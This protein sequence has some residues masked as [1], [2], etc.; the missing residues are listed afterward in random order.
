MRLSEEIRKLHAGEFWT[1]V[2]DKGFWE[3]MGCKDFPQLCNGGSMHNVDIHPFGIIIMH[4]SPLNT[5]GPCMALHNRYALVITVD[6]ATPMGGEVFPL[7]P[8]DG[9]GIAENSSWHLPTHEPCLAT[10]HNHVQGFS[11]LKYLDGICEVQ[12]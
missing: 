4:Q 9:I 1:I 6:W 11:S 8:S 3:N 2:S 5:C 12:L 10:R 7:G